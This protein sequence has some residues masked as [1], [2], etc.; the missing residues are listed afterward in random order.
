LRFQ[1]VASNRSTVQGAGA[2]VAGTRRS[3]STRTSSSGT[4]LHLIEIIPYFHRLENRTIWLFGFPQSYSSRNDSRAPKPRI[5]F[6]AVERLPT[7]VASR[8]CAEL[9]STD[10]IRAE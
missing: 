1:L 7:E 9:P 5:N 3:T 10:S 2:S 4:W 8:R 6:R